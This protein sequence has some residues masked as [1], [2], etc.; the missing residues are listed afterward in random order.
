MGMTYIPPTKPGWEGY[1]QLY[2]ATDGRLFVQAQF[3]AFNRDRKMAIVATYERIRQQQQQQQAAAAEAPFAAVRVPVLSLPP[4]PVELTSLPL[5][6]RTRRPHD[7]PPPLPFSPG[8]H[9]HRQ[10]ATR[11]EFKPGQFLKSSF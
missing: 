2:G 6:D 8:N 9:T 1:Y 3:A 7:A 11:E 10:G 4:V 5:F